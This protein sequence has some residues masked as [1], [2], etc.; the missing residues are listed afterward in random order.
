MTAAAQRGEPHV[1]GVVGD[2]REGALEHPLVRAAAAGGC[3]QVQLEDVPRGL[4]VRQVPLP[5]VLVRCQ[6]CDGCKRPSL[7]RV[8]MGATQRRQNERRDL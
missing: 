3:G 1:G 8:N 2:P 6:Q 5:W 7:L 4:E